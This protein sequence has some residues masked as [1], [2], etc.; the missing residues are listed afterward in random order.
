MPDRGWQTGRAFFAAGDRE[1][2]M[3]KTVLQLEQEAAPLQ[4]LPATEEQ[5]IDVDIGVNADVGR[6]VEPRAG[7]GMDRRGRWQ[8]PQVGRMAAQR[9]QGRG[10]HMMCSSD[11]ALFGRDAGLVARSVPILQPGAEMA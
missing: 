8:R 11:L 5:D 9:G 10:R 4:I 1:A 2:T 7:M 3:R 6:R